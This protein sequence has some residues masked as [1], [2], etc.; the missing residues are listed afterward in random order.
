M[1]SKHHFQFFHNRRAYQK[2]ANSTHSLFLLFTIKKDIF[3]KN[4]KYLFDLKPRKVVLELINDQQQFLTKLFET[5][6]TR[7][8]TRNAIFNFSRPQSY[9]KTANSLRYADNKATSHT[10]N[11]HLRYKKNIFEKLVSPRLESGWEINKN[12]L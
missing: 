7:K 10:S 4:Y 9:Q 2:T 12:A 5:L 8:Y 11:Y 1:F 3:M 6:K